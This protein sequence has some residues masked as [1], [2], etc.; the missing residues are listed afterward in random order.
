MNKKNRYFLFCLIL[1]LGLITLLL[2]ENYSRKKEDINEKSAI[3]NSVED[4]NNLEYD[5]KLSAWI[6]YWDLEVDYNIKELNTHLKELSYFAA[7]F[8]SNNNLIVSEDLLNYYNSTNKQNYTNYLTI[9]NDKKNSDTTYSLKDTNLLESL[10]K[11]E[12]S[13]KS[14]MEQ[15]INLAKIIILM[16]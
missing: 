9:V 12:N 6:V 13:R 1:I 7:D 16:V 3:L 14:H 5:D 2:Y 11:D 8:D 15:I 4:L 10:L